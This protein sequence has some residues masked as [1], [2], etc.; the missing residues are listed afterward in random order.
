[1]LMCL[2][3]S[4]TILLIIIIGVMLHLVV[5][6]PLNRGDRTIRACSSGLSNALKLVCSEGFYEPRSPSEFK[7]LP[8]SGGIVEECCH[9]ACSIETLQ[10]YCQ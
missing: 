3:R 10:Q 4:S 8:S 6:S 5:A 2:L 7:D 1:M 9:K